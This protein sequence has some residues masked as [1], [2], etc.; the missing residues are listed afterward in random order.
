MEGDHNT[1]V[2]GIAGRHGVTVTAMD[3]DQNLL[4]TA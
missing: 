3:A 2:A 1:T 4:L